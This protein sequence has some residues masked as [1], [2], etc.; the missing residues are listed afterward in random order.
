M[1]DDEKEGHSFYSD[2]GMAQHQ[3]RIKELV[4]AEEETAKINA[5]KAARKKGNK[6]VAGSGSSKSETSVR[7]VRD[8]EIPECPPHNQQ[9]VQ[10]SE[11][12]QPKL[13]GPVREVP[14]IQHRN[15]SPRKSNKGSD[16]VN[17]E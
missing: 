16:V 15:R 4:H 13:I 14:Q 6:G 9:E 8:N 7:V 2:W 17:R 11:D 5:R 12:P 1:R 3:K 10:A